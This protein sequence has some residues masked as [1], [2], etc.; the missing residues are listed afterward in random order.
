MFEMLNC[1][2]ID[3]LMR[4]INIPFLELKKPF[5]LKAP[6]VLS[7]VVINAKCEVGVIK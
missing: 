6:R 5:I 4:V 2:L 1:I 3:N 7:N